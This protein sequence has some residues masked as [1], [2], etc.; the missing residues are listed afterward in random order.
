MVGF[1]KF[2]EIRNQIENTRRKIVV[3]YVIATEED[4]VELLKGWDQL[5]IQEA[6]L[7]ALEAEWK[8]LR[9]IV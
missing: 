2:E 5:N 1:E 6:E 7:N 9:G 4:R 3:A 8:L